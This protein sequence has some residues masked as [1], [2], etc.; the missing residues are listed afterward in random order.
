[1]W[2]YKKN[3]EKIK[4]ILTYL[5]FNLKLNILSIKKK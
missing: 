3:I 1:M 2:I 4:L 5:L